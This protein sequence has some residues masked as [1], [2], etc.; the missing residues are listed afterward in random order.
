MG[1][2]CF[3]NWPK[4]KQR[5]LPG[6]G[7]DAEIERV[8]DGLDLMDAAMAEAKVSPQHLVVMVNG[9]IGRYFLS[10]SFF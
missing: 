2:G 6:V 3:G 8:A 9:L 7:E 10:L 1:S 5:Q 4:K